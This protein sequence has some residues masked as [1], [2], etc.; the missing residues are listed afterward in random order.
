MARINS[1]K[2]VKPTKLSIL[3]GLAIAITLYLYLKDK[4]I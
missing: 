2:K 3:F 1:K 4:S